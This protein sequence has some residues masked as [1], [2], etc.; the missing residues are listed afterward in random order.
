M[1]SLPHA[2]AP[3]AKPEEN[4]GPVSYYKQIRPILQAN[5][6]GCHQPAK[7]QGGYVM[8]DFAKLLAG[9]DSKDKTPAVL[10]GNPDKS[11]L[12]VQIVPNAKGEAEMP[13]GKPPLL[14]M[15]IELLK[16]WLTEGAH[17]DTPANVRQRYDQDHLPVYTMPPV[18]T[19]LDYS[20]D[21]KV[22]AVAGFHEVLLHKADGSGLAARLVGL[23]ERIESV[24]FSP[25]GKS[26]AVAG[27]QPGRMGEIQ[28]W[29]V[30]KRKLRLS[31]PVTYDTVYGLSWSP[32]GTAISFGCSDNTVRAITIDRRPA[33]TK[34]L[35][36]DWIA[37]AI[38]R[39][40]IG[41]DGE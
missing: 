34:D 4:K 21:G 8:T 33:R 36:S 25:D 1:P 11:L 35:H 40:Y 13:K 5:C 24:R 28:I 37:N 14:A 18:V 15:E 26:L 22:L 30:E 32:D 17:D 20:P 10:A 6:Q 29:E 19:S 31:V 2:A 27:G 3:A 39:R 41:R 38:L 16:K 23:S 12:Y 7:A 9:G